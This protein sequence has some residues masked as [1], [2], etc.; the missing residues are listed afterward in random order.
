MWKYLVIFYFHLH[1]FKLYLNLNK[2]YT[3]SLGL[4]KF[5]VVSSRRIGSPFVE[6]VKVEKFCWYSSEIL[7]VFCVHCAVA[8]LRHCAKSREVEGLIHD[9]VTGIFNLHN[10]SGRTL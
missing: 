2:L 3:P 4:L 7:M 10:P 5:F 6:V 8:Q 1:I 9:C